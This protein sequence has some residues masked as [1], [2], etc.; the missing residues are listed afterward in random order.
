MASNVARIA[1]VCGCMAAMACS[2]CSADIWTASATQ[3]PLDSESNFTVASTFGQY[4]SS[5]LWYGLLEFMIEHIGR[6]HHLV[7]IVFV[8]D[9]TNLGHGNA[10]FYQS[11]PDFR[12]N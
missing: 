5:D 12:A 1:A 7:V 11:C 4:R 9:T 3:K 10:L 2:A 6:N 8:R